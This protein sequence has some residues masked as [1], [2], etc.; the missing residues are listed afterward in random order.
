MFALEHGYDLA[1]QVDGD[2]QHDAGQ[3]A[4]LRDHLERSPE[5]HMVTGSRFLVAAKPNGNGNGH[6]HANSRCAGNGNAS[7]ANRL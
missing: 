7:Q 4:S 6:G 3:I 5:L 1:V 2:G